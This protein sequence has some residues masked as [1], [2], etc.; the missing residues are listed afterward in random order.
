MFCSAGVR[1]GLVYHWPLE[2]NSG[3]LALDVAFTNHMT[4]VGTP[5]I[6]PGKVGNAFTFD[7]LP[8]YLNIFHTPDNSATGLPIYNGGKY[9]I[10]MWTKGP[11]QTAKLIF[12]EGST[13]SATPLLILQ[14]GQAAAN[15]NKLDV[16]IRGASTPINH[17]V[18][19]TVVFDDVWHHIAWADDSGTVRLY[20]DGVLD[21]A[22]FN[23]T[24]IAPISFNTTAIGTL[25][26]ATV[27]TNTFQGQI[28]EVA[29]WERAL[30]ESEVLE[31]LTKGVPAPGTQVVAPTF[32]RQPV[33]GTNQVGD[34]HIF[35]TGVSGTRPFTFQWFRN[36]V[37]IPGATNETYRA[38]S[39]TFAN[40]GDVYRVAV[41]NVAGSIISSNATLIVVAE[42]Q[43]DVRKGLINY[44]PLNK[45]NET[46][47]I[48]IT[49]DLYSGNDMVL[50]NFANANDLVPG[51]FSNALG[52][53]FTTKYTYRTNGSPI[54][55][56]TN[57]SV[58]M[59]LKAPFETQNDRRVFSEGSSVNNNPLFTIGTDTAAASP[60]ARVF[61]RSDAGVSTEVSARSSAR[62]VFDDT[63]HHLVWTDA[64]GV[65]KLYIDG[66]LDETD[67]TYTRLPLTVSITS[68]GGVLRAVPGNFYFGNIDEVGTWNRVLTWTEIQQI[69]SAGIPS[70]VAAIP[71]SIT[72]QS[73]SRTNGVFTGDTVSLFVQTIGTLPLAFQWHGPSGA[74]SGEANASARAD[75]L[76]LTNLQ[77]SQSG[78]Y[79]VSITNQAGQVT[80]QPIQLVV[81]PHIPVTSGEVLKVDVGLTGVS[82][83]QPG[84]SEFSLGING[85][86][87]NGIGVT[88]TGIG[89]AL[90][91]R[92]RTTGRFVTNDPPA[93][94]QAQIYNDF[95][96]ANSTA[97]GTGLRVL[98]E[99]LAPN[100]RYAVTLWSFDAASTGA[101]FADWTETASGTPVI[102]QSSYTFDGNVLP[103]KDL[104]Y[105]LQAE[106]ISSATGKLQLE[107]L[108]NG[109][110]SFGV[111]FNGLRL[112]ANPGSKPIQI[113]SAQLVNGKIRLTI[114][115]QQAGQNITIQQSTDIAPATW[116]PA[117]GGGVVQTQGTTVT[118][119]FTPNASRMFF[120]VVVAP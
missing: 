22:N 73:A 117:T 74:I 27:N 88:V 2:A 112:V 96:F 75:T 39:L 5:V 29:I 8:T 15:N 119:E 9:T 23:Y 17:L 95:I 21:T 46:N 34:W 51:Q 47:G 79:F 91:E 18:S 89:A 48:L 65:G 80:S 53:D 72:A 38:L 98:V 63:W 40:S 60:S 110:T 85:T 25:V 50:V 11:A 24:P 61:I 114:E 78:S 105:T 68:L 86:N 81:T 120:R 19:S 76:V 87:Y 30:S 77:P 55:N 93:L 101:R 109:G 100:T 13:A 99:R 4:I 97:D 6:E 12:C 82:N 103:V 44:W 36:D 14:T 26:R 37:A 16:I 104:E 28:D 49:P 59:W 118:A 66:V 94:T 45:I 102:L 54:Y 113:T 92:N 67:F 35:S 33:S 41:T 10:T 43:P 111:F 107:G 90:A 42:P 83:L 84:F 69:K 58:S 62:P 106:L 57:Y 71:P 115:T 70:P 56:S 7:G 3:G 32:D 108:K 1:D 31:V 64:N 116:V 20:I 52:F